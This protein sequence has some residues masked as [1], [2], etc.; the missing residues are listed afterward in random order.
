M[1]GARGRSQAPSAATRSDSGGVDRRVTVADQ[2]ALHVRQWPGSRRPFLLV[3]G[4]SSNARLWDPVATRL[5]AAGHPVTAVDLRSHG[6]SDAPPAGYDTATAASDLAAL[7][8]PGAVVAGQSWGGNVAVELAARHPE[9]VAG[10]ALVD[11]GWIAPAEEFPTWEECEAALRPPKIDGLAASQLE[12]FI[13]SG[14]PGWSD[15]AVA[16]T[17][18][19]LR[20]WPDGTL[21]RRLSIERHMQIVRSMWDDP[22]Q[23]YYSAIT[24]PVLLIPVIPADLHGSEVRRARIRAAADA[25]RDATIREYV[26]GDHD[27]HAQHPDELAAD[28]LGLAARI[29]D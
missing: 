29:G 25:M 20:V 28:L 2:I 13:R 12:G 4:L 1:P 8:I 11:G 6:E 3:H 16:A 9:L 10:L 26:G 5:A 19:N 21:T 27:L 22:P 15:A 14:H 17:I 24:A 23:P 18:A 7:G